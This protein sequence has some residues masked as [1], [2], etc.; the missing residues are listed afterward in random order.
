MVMGETNIAT[1]TTQLD[2]SRKLQ[3]SDEEGT[4]FSTETISKDNTLTNEEY[5][6]RAAGD[7][8][9]TEEV[10]IKTVINPKLESRMSDRQRKAAGMG[11]I[12]VKAATIGR[13]GNV[14]KSVNQEIL[15]LTDAI[16]RGGRCLC[17]RSK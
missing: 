3:L 1:V 13:V 12:E 2:G 11:A 7:I 9:T 4:P 5:V 14:Q 17:S 8:K 15:D 16:R 10:D 6:T